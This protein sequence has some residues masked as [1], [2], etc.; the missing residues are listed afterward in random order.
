[1]SKFTPW[2]FLTL[3][4]CFV[5]A[6][7]GVWAGEAATAGHGNKL[8]VLV[9]S[10]GHP[11]PVKPFRAVLA[12]FPD[13]ECTFVEEKQGAE[14]F[15]DVGN[16]PFDAI[17]LYNFM[18]KPTDKQWG[19]FSSLLD[20]GVGLVI[21]HHAIYG[22]RPRP[23]FQKIVGV[24]S[25]LSGAKDDFDIR[26]HV[27]DPRHPITKGLA[28]FSIRDEVYKGHKLDPKAHVLL[29]TD[30]PANEKAIAWVHTYRKSPVCYFQLG[31]DQK[32]YDKPE[33]GAILGRAIRWSAG[34]LKP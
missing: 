21:L 13:M 33:F 30:Q 34:R 25:W 17:L 9:V 6:L 14:A 2:M 26:V 3:F 16:W 4:S 1:M 22:Y 11:F 27:E 19:N 24:T 10:G 23:E 29:T 31:H 15:E 20:R 7:S 28:D 5:P 8:R 32:A 12:A 18:R